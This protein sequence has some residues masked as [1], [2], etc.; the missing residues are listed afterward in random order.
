MVLVTGDGDFVPPVKFAKREGLQFS[1]ITFE[2]NVHSGLI[3][4]ADFSLDIANGQDSALKGGQGVGV[5]TE[6]EIESEKSD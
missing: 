6:T 4:H 3:E 1:V 5:P 2:H